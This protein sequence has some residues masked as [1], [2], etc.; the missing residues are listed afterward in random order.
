MA[1]VIAILPIEIVIWVFN[2]ADVIALQVQKADVVA[3]W[4]M[5]FA[6]YLINIG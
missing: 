3:L 5:E 4:L 2:K 1:D 6:P